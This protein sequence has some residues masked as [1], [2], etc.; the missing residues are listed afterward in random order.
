[1]KEALLV[2]TADCPCACAFCE[3][4]QNH[5]RR[6]GGKTLGEND[7]KNI[8]DKLAYEGLKIAIITGGE[9][10]LNKN[11]VFNLINYLHAKNIYV[12]LNTS[13]VL[14]K[15]KEL[16]GELK[17]NYPDLL[18]FS[19][20][21][22]IPSQHDGNRGIK[23]LFQ[24][25]EDTIDTL[26]TSGDHSV[27]VRFV[28][29][30]QN[31]KQIPDLLLHFNRKGVECIKFTNIENDKDGSFRL[32]IEDLEYYDQYVRK[33]TID[34]LKQC[35]FSKP[36]KRE[37][38][39]NKAANFLNKN[40]IDYHCFAKGVFSPSLIK[41]AYCGELDRF[42]LVEPNGDILPCC[43]SEYHY[44]PVCGN[45]LTEDFSDILSSETYLNLK[46]H[47]Q[48]YCIYCTEPHNMQIDFSDKA[49]PV[50]QRWK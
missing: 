20:D 50:N 15:N 49:N 39:I 23:G 41:N 27:A 31:Y 40:N 25:I 45:L 32:T 10:I 17:N 11:K 43:E 46:K 28:V 35:N 7:W 24:V 9:A 34:A 29:T 8:I 47:R 18:V 37:E 3:S 38:A 33:E 6:F 30:K 36:E 13:G 19:I 4:K 14:F 16:V 1:M 42:C 2:L 21:S 12:V 44:A 26:K 22:V 48:E 5:L